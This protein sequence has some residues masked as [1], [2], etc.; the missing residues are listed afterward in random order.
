VIHLRA[1]SSDISDGVQIEVSDPSL[2]ED[3]RGYLQRNG[4][5]S[6]QNGPGKFEVRVLWPAE[7]LRSDTADRLKIFRHLREWCADHPG[8]HAN[9]LN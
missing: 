1:R 4:C 3:L 2:V 5:P 6:E 7:S 8:V 9:I